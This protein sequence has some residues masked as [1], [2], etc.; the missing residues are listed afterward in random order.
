MSHSIELNTDIELFLKVHDH[1]CSSDIGMSVNQKF[2]FYSRC[3]LWSRHTTY[4]DLLNELRVAWVSHFPRTCDRLS[5]ARTISYIQKIPRKQYRSH[6]LRTYYSIKDYN[7]FFFTCLFDETVFK[8]GLFADAS[9]HIDLEHL[10]FLRE[11]LMSDREAVFSLSTHAVN[12]ILLSSYFFKHTIET[13]QLFQYFLEVGDAVT[14]PNVRDDLDARI[15]FYTHIIIGA[16]Y[17]YAREIPKDVRMVCNNMLERVEQ[18]IDAHYDT[19]SL[20]QKNEFLVCAAMC[21]YDT[22]LKKRIH[23]EL[24]QSISPHGPFF[25][26]THNAYSVQG[27]NVTAASVEHSNVLALM[28]FVPK[29]AFRGDSTKD[30][31]TV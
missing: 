24:V 9:T 7:T 28:A 27:G 10:T 22:P 8:G 29:D 16:S 17:F 13:T 12:F 6:A 31:Y 18:L 23:D 15:Y 25:K 20:D 4:L 14:L 30:A 19:L 5:R 26:N 21:A 11:R 2:H 1:Y 3:Y